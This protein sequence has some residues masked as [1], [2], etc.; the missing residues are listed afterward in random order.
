[1]TANN[2]PPAG[3]A[4]LLRVLDNLPLLVLEKR[5]RLGLSQRAA[6]KQTGLTFSTICRAEQG[7][8]MHLSTAM[9]LVEWVGKP[10]AP[11]APSQERTT[12]A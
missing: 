7:Y 2:E 5:R 9:Q 8:D 6:A 12:D 11:P 4:E 10:D 3:Y 1:M